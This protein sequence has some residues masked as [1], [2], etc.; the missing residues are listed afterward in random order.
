MYSIVPVATIVQDHLT[1]ITEAMITYVTKE[2][3][4]DMISDLSEF[5]LISC[6]H[7]SM[8]VY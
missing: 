5:I 2:S 3:I 8:Y 6:C 7:I 1:T 4:H